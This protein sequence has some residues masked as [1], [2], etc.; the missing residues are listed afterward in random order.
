MVNAISKRSVDKLLSIP[1][2]HEFIAA[3][4]QQIL[5]RAPDS[6]GMAHYLSRL[7]GGEDRLTVA[8]ELAA[9]DEASALPSG[10]KVV[11]TEIL[12]R[13]SQQLI[14]SSWT[15]ARRRRSARQVE[16]YL[17]AVCGARPAIDV[18]AVRSGTVQDPFSTYLHRVIEDRR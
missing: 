7:Q 9:S 14:S 2:E 4:Y 12:V 8:A 16:R 17:Q 13:H 10:T 5:Y 1:G 15:P 11:M 18:S 6:S 3:S